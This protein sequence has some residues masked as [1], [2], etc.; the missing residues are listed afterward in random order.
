MQNWEK[1]FY[2]VILQRGKDYYRKKRVKILDADEL[3]CQA[4]VRGAEPYYVQIT[5]NDDYDIN[6]A[7]KFIKQFVKLQ[8]S[9]K[10]PAENKRLF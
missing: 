4:I 10:I 1:R 5:L 6:R 7:S 9:H 3:S 2:S 8:N